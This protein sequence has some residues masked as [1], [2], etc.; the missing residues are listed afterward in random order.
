MDKGPD[1][2]RREMV[3][4]IEQAQVARGFSDKE[5][6]QR[7]G[8]SR[9]TLWGIK[10]GT[11]KRPRMTTLEN[12]A[13]ALAMDPEMANELRSRE[14]TVW[15]RVVRAVDVGREEVEKGQQTP[16]FALY[17][18]ALAMTVG[19]PYQFVGDTNYNFGLG[20]IRES[21]EQKEE[22]QEQ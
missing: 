7:A 8:I 13:R 16:G 3:K 15:E 5:L 19:G 17:N 11:V 2:R 18:V 10:N 14:Q 6:A 22:P 20:P 9:T 1:E 21:A 12:I 4:G